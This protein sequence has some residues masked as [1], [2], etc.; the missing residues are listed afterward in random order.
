MGRK[1]L[2]ILCFGDSLTSGYFCWGMD[3]HPYAL[4]LEDRLTGAFPDVDFEVVADGKPG[5]VASF[6]RF[7]RRMEAAW[8]KQTY[9][10]TIIL[11]GTNDIAYCI[12]PEQ[13]FEALKDLYDIALSREHKVLA[14]TVPECHS[15]G[16]RGTRDRNELNQMI[17]NNEDTN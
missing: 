15:K 2:R 5:D 3:S 11:G 13:I 4:K 6:E 1:T 14:L 16:E 12:P 9:D 7:R 17:L 8:D 10:W